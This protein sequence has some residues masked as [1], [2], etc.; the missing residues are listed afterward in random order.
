MNDK[1]KV[2]IF[3]AGCGVCDETIQ[4]V[5][6]IACDSCEVEVLEMRQEM[7]AKRA[8]DLGIKTIP[9]IVI[10]GKIAECCA[11]RE[12]DKDTLRSAGLGT[13]LS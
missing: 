6:E 13:P 5:R 12:V 8:E 10:D 4:M 1:R 2:E 3:S 11:N 9:T 7:V